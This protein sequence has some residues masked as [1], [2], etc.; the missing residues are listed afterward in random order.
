MK[1]CIGDMGEFA[2]TFL[3]IAGFT[4]GAIVAILWIWATMYLYSLG[5]EE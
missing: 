4:A 1:A 5:M 2:I 3:L